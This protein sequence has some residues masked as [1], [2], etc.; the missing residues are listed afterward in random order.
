MSRAEVI[1]GVFATRVM[2]IA[3]MELISPSNT[4]VSSSMKKS[5]SDGGM[6]KARFT[7]AANWPRVTGSVG[8]AS[9]GPILVGS[10]RRRA[11]SL[12]LRP[13]ALHHQ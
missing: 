3:A 5:V 6:S 2:P 1:I 9:A 12:L 8:Q 10:R 7:R 13:S 11:D 4:L